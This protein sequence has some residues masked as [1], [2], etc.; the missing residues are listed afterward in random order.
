VNMRQGA[1]KLTCR[2]ELVVVSDGFDG[3]WV[4]GLGGGGDMGDA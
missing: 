2:A 1:E 4:D 3:R